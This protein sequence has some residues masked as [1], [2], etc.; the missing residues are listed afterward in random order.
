[1]FN[2]PLMCILG[3]EGGGHMVV[4]DFRELNQKL[5]KQTITFKSVQETLGP[6]K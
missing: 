3:I 2:T 1:M 4:Q 5:D 6:I